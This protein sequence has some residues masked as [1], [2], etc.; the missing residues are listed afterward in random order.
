MGKFSRNETG[1]GSPQIRSDQF[2]LYR[3][4]PFPS[5]SF[6]IPMSEYQP[7]RG[8]APA[9]RRWRSSIGVAIAVCCSTLVGVGIG[10]ATGD[11]VSILAEGM[12]LTST[13][14]GVPFPDGTDPEYSHTAAVG[15]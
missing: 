1:N 9:P 11:R 14:I 15:Q 7:I 13:N 8:S 5:D 3:R 4:E 6:N 2:G 12:G 10:I